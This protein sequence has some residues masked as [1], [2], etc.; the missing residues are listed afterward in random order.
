MSVCVFGSLSLFRKFVFRAL[1]LF[2]CLTDYLI[3]VRAPTILAKLSKGI[4][5]MA[6]RI[7]YSEKYQ[8]DCFEY[9]SSPRPAFFRKILYRRMID[10]PP[11]QAVVS[12]C[13][14]A[15]EPAEDIFDAR[16]GNPLHHHHARIHHVFSCCCVSPA[17]ARVRRIQTSVSTATLYAQD[18]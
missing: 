4:I 10:F 9:R 11:L 15:K 7:E 17:P 18:T 16:H 2:L 1:S 14:I 3:K 12:V 8:D 13:Q 5:I 6:A